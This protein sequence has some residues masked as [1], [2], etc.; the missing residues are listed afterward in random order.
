[1][2]LMVFLIVCTLGV[3]TDI[4]VAMIPLSSIELR[5][6]T[7]KRYMKSSGTDLDFRSWHFQND[8]KT[9]S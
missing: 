4:K 7:V 6:M 8:F 9:S 5:L 1:M 3:L 2:Q